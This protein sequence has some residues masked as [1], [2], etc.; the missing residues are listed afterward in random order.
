VVG[1]LG[2]GFGTSCD[3]LWDVGTCGGGAFGGGSP[4]KVD[5]EAETGAAV[6]RGGTVDGD[7]V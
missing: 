2:G 4:D 5:E 6:V 3:A 1:P 7:G